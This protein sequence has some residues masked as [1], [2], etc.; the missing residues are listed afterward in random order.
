M[1]IR[2]DNL[3][4]TASS[5]IWWRLPRR[6]G[7]IPLIA[8]A[9]KAMTD[10]SKPDLQS[11]T[12]QGGMALIFRS[13]LGKKLIEMVQRIASSPAAVLIE[14]ETG[15]GK[16]LIARSIHHFSLRCHKPLVDVNCGALPDH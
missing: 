7:E 1:V 3:L 2:R 9:R 16:E 14:G 12:L 10:K 11:V 8:R 5:S 15:T 13:A 6:V 4:L